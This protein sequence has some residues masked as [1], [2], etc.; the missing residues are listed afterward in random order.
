M[1][2]LFNT[3]EHRAA[4]D[5]LGASPNSRSRSSLGS[6]AVQIP[7]WEALVVARNGHPL[8]PISVEAAHAAALK[9]LQHKTIYDRLNVLSKFFQIYHITL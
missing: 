8:L 9:L 5:L 6:I 3:P 7:T 4:P 2:V 1:R